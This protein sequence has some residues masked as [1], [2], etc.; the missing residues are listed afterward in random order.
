MQMNTLKTFTIALLCLFGTSATICAQ[1]R[2]SKAKTPVSP[3][4]E[5]MKKLADKLP[6]TEKIL[7][8]DSIVV[9][10]ENMQT[11]L[12]LPRHLGR[13]TTYA[14][15][16]G[17]QAPDTWMAYCNEFGDRC[18]FSMADTDGHMHIYS[19][20]KVG[21]K[22][23]KPERI[24]DFDHLFEDITC[25]YL[26]DD[27]STL[28]FAA[29]GAESIGGYDIYRTAFD[30]ESQKYITP[31]NMGLPYNSTADDYYCIISD[32][33]TLGWLATNRQQ[34]AGKAC[35]YSFVRSEPRLDYSADNMSNEQMLAR[36]EIRAISE[37]WK[38]WP[39]KNARTKAIRRKAGLKTSNYA[40][41]SENTEFVVNDNVTYNSIDQ[42]R[43]T[44]NKQRYAK[45]MQMRKTSTQLEKQLENL[46]DQYTQA[47]KGTQR[48]MATAI[49]KAEEQ[50]YRMQTDMAALEKE[51]R[52]KENQ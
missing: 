4:E 19:A 49:T 9:N 25:P 7:V 18:L 45:L 33:D 27:G 1:T 52:N 15:M 11:A 3:Q 8:F 47:G 50:L 16:F 22:W 31:E 28:Y 29:R 43:S 2:K 35:V 5:L 6:Y 20:D 21:T 23:T 40:E 32:V 13:I 10:K 12:S 36:A 39:D 46:R 14:Q 48:R 42:F 26:S 41:H 51:I 34:P 30:A 44:A 24:E 38:D 37:T 17:T